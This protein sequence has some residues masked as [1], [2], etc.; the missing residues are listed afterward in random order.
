M[1]PAD[2]GLSRILPP[3]S[4]LCDLWQVSE[5]GILYLSNGHNQQLIGCL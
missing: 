4:L 3:G 5:P 1:Q 2:S